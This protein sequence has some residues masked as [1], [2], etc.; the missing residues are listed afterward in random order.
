MRPITHCGLGLAL[1]S[2][3]SDDEINRLRRRVNAKEPDRSLHISA[4]SLADQIEIVRRKG[5]SFSR[6]LFHEGVSFV[7]VALKEP[8]DGRW[9]AL[10]VGGM[11]SALAEQEDMIAAD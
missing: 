9:S 11:I 1:L 3:Q 4:R 10:G 2:R 6:G 5:Y 8:L 7:G